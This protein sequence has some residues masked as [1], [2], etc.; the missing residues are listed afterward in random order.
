[1][2]LRNFD[3]ESS[4][5]NRNSIF[6][7]LLIF[8]I[9]CNKKSTE[10][11]VKEWIVDHAITIKTVKA[12][13]GFDDLEPFREMVGDAR[14][15]SLGEPTHG[16]KEVFQLKHRIIEYLVTEMGFNIFA[17]ECPFGEAY[18]INRYVVDGIGDPE[19][20]IA[21]IYYWAWD[22]QEVLEMLKWM[23]DYNAK[24]TTK[25][26]VKFYG[27][28]TQ[29]PE[30]AARVMLEYLDKVDPEL[31]K[32]VRP[33]LS[34]LEVAFSNPEIIGGRQFIPEEYDSL[35]LRDIGLVMEALDSKKDTYIGLSSL[36]DW[37][38]A[39]QHARQV[40]MYI[41]ANTK[42]G[43]NYS[44]IR[45]LGQAQNL[46]WIMDHEGND[47]KMIVW[48]HNSHVSN[49]SRWGIEWMGAHMKK[50]YGDEIKIFGFFFNQ[51]Q[52]KAVDEGVPSK[53]MY[54]FSVDP[55]PEETFE[56][57]MAN[58]NYSIA[59]LDI[60]K[61]P[62][63]GVVYDWFNQER[64][65]RNSGGGYNENDAEHF[66]WP[67]NLMEAYDVLVYIDSTTAVKDINDADYDNMWLVNKKLDKPT[68]TDFEN[69]GS[70]EAPNDWVAWSK[71]QRLGVKMIVSNKDPYNGKYSAILKRDKDLKYG[72]IT[73]SLRQYID[74]SPYRGKKIRFKIRAR[75]ELLESAFT[76]VRLSIDPKQLDD[77]HDGLPPLFD[78]LDKYRVESTEWKM[79][80]IEAHV[81]E[82][83]DIIHYGIY[84]R[85]FGSV[86]IDDIEILVEE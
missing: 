45:D 16:N 81:D 42:D 18:D 40:E 36:S 31:S 56:Y 26:K 63:K 12:H 35:S 3:I 33:E 71:F 78:S 80:E 51:G 73:P 69:N 65:S 32:R 66:F 62:K 9:S 29:N 37:T 5:I 47:A 61:I 59:A 53:G 20:A 8:F 67:Y 48:A 68:N 54:D 44:L 60:T 55:A 24:P 82:N 4:M 39:R 15:V 50:W 76:F 34:I 77:A 75:A 21:G 27:F 83:A 74:A 2:P 13:S 30:R 70:G 79:Y 10:D 28:D 7:L 72:E 43:E 14:I 11:E 64:P 23:H 57:M 25:E 49:S 17:L 38:L 84:L 58:N 86:W 1:M 46:K 41:E 19:K 52:F 22:T 85:D 6:L